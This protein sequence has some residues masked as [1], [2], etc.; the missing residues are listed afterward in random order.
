M[1]ER[2]NNGIDIGYRGIHGVIRG[3]LAI[4]ALLFGVV[5]GALVYVNYDGFR[6][7]RALL[8]QSSADH[9]LLSCVVSLTLKEREKLREM[10]TRS[11]FQQLCPWL[12]P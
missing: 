9:D 2:G 6:D 12:R 5:G 1:P 10:R 3:P 7:V 11:E 8:R 4:I